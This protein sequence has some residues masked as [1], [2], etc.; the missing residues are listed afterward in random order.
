MVEKSLGNVNCVDDNQFHGLEGNCTLYNQVY[1]VLLFK[2]VII[3]DAVVTFLKSGDHK[4]FSCQRSLLNESSV[5][6]KD[7]WN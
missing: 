3:L 6:I 7:E 2:D 5:S 4:I 1:L